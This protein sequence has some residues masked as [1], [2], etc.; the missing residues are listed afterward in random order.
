M[1]LNALMSKNQGLVL[2]ALLAPLDTMEMDSSVLV[3][4]AP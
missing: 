2:L 4:Y 3:S 1:M